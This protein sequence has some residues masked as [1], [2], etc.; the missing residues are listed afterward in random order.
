MASGLA[1]FD[2]GFNSNAPCFPSSNWVVKTLSARTGSAF[3]SGCDNCFRFGLLGG[4]AWIGVIHSY[5]PASIITEHQGRY[6]HLKE[7]AVI[8]QNRSGRWLLAFAKEC[9][10]LAS[11][12]LLLYSRSFTRCHSLFAILGPS[13]VPNYVIQR[14]VLRGT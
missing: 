2:S 10:F 7:R 8:V 1:L 9:G 14:F 4:L 12:A 11:R 3:M 13:A 6:G 5:Y